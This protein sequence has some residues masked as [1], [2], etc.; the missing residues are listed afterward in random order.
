MLLP[1]SRVGM[2]A[3][4]N[5]ASPARKNGMH[6]SQLAGFHTGINSLAD[7][8]WL[9]VLQP[10]PLQ[11]LVTP[12]MPSPKKLNPIAHKCQQVHPFFQVQVQVQH[13]DK[14]QILLAD[15]PSMR[16]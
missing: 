8:D 6:A 10:G 4:S 7:H 2:V 14:A 3:A 11:H 12:K 15:M 16:S 9:Q 13:A 5:T 1:A